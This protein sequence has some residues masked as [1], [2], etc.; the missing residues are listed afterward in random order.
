M[1]VAPGA[2]SRIE[3]TDS[4]GEANVSLSTGTFPYELTL[5]VGIDVVQDAERLYERAPCEEIGNLGLRGPPALWLAR[6]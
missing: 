6:A 4:S 1:T 3:S 2:S 5:L